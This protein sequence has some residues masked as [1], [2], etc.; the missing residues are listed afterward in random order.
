VTELPSADAVKSTVQGET[1][2]DTVAQQDAALAVMQMYVSMRSERNVAAVGA[3]EGVSPLAA[4]RF[5]E[6]R[7]AQ[8]QPRTVFENRLSSA[9]M[10]YFDDGRFHSRVLSKLV[11]L[12]SVRPTHAD[13]PFW[14][15]TG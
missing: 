3:S 1:P 4:Q 7:R 8:T 10:A 12:E 14:P 9:A 6:Y 5:E 11:S 15:F 13:W 2:V